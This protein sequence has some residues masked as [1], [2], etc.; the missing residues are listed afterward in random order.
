MKTG[1]PNIGD[2]IAYYTPLL[3]RYALR[4]I[5]DESVA[6][7]LVKQVLKDQYDIDELAPSKHLRRVLKTDLLNRCHYWKQSQ[8]FDRPLVKVPVRKYV[9]P[10]AII[11]D[12]ENH[13]LN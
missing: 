12:N 4:L 3:E 10:H 8:I 7:K 5:N 6:A 13:P 1:K 2:T 11:D 9:K